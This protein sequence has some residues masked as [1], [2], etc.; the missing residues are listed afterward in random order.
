MPKKKLLGC[1]FPVFIVVA[2]L[3]LVL[4][5]IGLASGPLKPILSLVGLGNLV[6]PSWLSVPQPHPELPAEVVFHFFGFPVTNSLI[7]AWFT[8]IVLVVFIGVVAR[9]PKFIPG[10]AQTVLEFI[11]GSFLL[12]FCQRVA[13]ESNG[14]RFFPIV[15]T[16]FLFV[17]FNAWLSLLPGFGSI[18]ITN[19]EG[20]EVHLLR[21]A[22]TDL[23]TPL[24]LALISFVAVAYFGLRALGIRYVG[25]FINVGGFFAGVGLLFRG[26]IG[27]GLSG[28][29]MGF[30]NFFIGLIELVSQLIRIV[31]FTL[32][33]FGNM[34]AGEILL[35]VATF[36]LPF[37]FADIFYGLELLVGFVQA[38]IFSSLTLIFL[39]LA[40]S[41]HGGDEHGHEHGHENSHEKE[42]SK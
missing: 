9:R 40:V 32:R 24:A 13:G 27:A 10:R 15:A 34:T 16:I 29:F 26:R 20:H 8:I 7:A 6:V 4:F 11:L 31:S 37:V 17:I 25:Q 42:T 12:S 5:V 28:M 36:L 18:L 22:N 30:I 39:T 23:N 2:V 3:V 41:A 33:L 14:R 38:L 35:L 1:S 21:G 19:P